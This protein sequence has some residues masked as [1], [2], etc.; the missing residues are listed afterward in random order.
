MD[1]EERLDEEKEA[2]LDVDTAIAAVPVKND[3]AFQTNTPVINNN[4]T[5][6]TKSN[7]KPSLRPSIRFDS[8][9]LDW[10]EMT[11]GDKRDFKFTF[12]NTGDADLVITKATATCGC[13]V[14]SYPFLPIAPKET[15]F[16]GVNYNSVG[17]SGRQKA[18]ITI[19]T[20][21][22]PSIHKLYVEGDVLD[23]QEGN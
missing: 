1:I 16:I 10:G 3:T 15:G 20:N 18:T 17:K 12:T 14:P 5:V 22:Q 11:A 21:A 2:L 8:T 6:H 23:K 13:T 4:S 9:A 7:S 19:L